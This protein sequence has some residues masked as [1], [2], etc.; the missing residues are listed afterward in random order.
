MRVVDIT[1]HDRNV[2]LLRK[3]TLLAKVQ[4][5]LNIRK[6]LDQGVWTET[7]SGS[8]LVAKS[9]SNQNTR[10]RTQFSVLVL[11]QL[12]IRNSFLNPD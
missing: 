5:D 11:G 10:I 7:E 12:D 6:I 9:R 8:S 1:I 3:N 4:S 2:M